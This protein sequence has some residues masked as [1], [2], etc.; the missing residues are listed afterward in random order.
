M[1]TLFVI[2]LYGHLTATYESASTRRFREGRVDCIRSA[3]NEA[4]AWCA[5]MIPSGLLIE[6]N[7]CDDFQ[8]K[9]V[10]F[11]L[12]DVSITY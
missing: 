5:V 6:N 11:S 2:R 1:F 7:E 8:S 10:T 4:L 12:H 9:R 3:T